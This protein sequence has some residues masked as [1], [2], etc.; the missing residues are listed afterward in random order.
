MRK[1]I[2]LILVLVGVFLILSYLI[3]CSSNLL[4]K[5]KKD[6]S[7]LVKVV[8]ITVYYVQMSSRDEGELVAEEHIVPETSNMPKRAL[9]ELIRGEPKNRNAFL[10]FPK[11]TRVLT[12]KIEDGVATVNFSKE[13]LDTKSISKKA[14]TVG[15]ASIVAT[16]TE[17][18]E[19][20]KV[21]FLVEGKDKG[22][23]DGKNIEDWWGYGGIKKQPFSF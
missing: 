12:V 15:I 9:Q 8:P 18:K 13:V 7:T 14:E 5:G 11:K 3:G 16:L 1:N 6:K 10:V 4:N 2:I 23:I 21:R 17:F 19:I 22:K 20:D